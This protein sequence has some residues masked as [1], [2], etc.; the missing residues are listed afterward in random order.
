MEIFPQFSPCFVYSFFSEEFCFFNVFSQKVF[1]SFALFFF[2]SIVLSK[3]KFFSIKKGCFFLKI[4]MCFFFEEDCFFSKG[5]GFQF[6]EKYVFFFFQFVLLF[7]QN[8]RD[9][10]F[11]QWFFS[12]KSIF[13]I[14]SNGFLFRSFFFPE[15]FFFRFFLS[16]FFFSRFFF[17][18]KVFFFQGYLLDVFFQV[19]FF[20]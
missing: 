15:V 10:F 12:S 13:S 2:V 9:F 3:K 18:R 20:K 19:F 1:F 7:L 17:Q 5:I 6:F 14:F 8:K 16:R 4:G 11:L